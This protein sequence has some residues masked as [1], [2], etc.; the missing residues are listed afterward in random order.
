MEQKRNGIYNS[1][2]L[3]FEESST[4]Q[5]APAFRQ[6]ETILQDEDFNQ[7]QQSQPEEEQKEVITQNKV[8]QYEEE[9]KKIGFFFVVWN[10]ISVLG[11]VVF[12]FVSMKF[13]F[14]SD[15]FHT[16]M[17]MLLAAHV[18]IFVSLFVFSKDK[19]KL[20]VRLKNYKAF[21]SATN[22]ILRISN[23]GLSIG[24][25]VQSIKAGNMNSIFSILST[26][27][28]I[29]LILL[30][31]VFDILCIVFRKRFEYNKRHIRELMKKSKEE[32][33]K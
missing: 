21:A 33:R 6:I 32:F 11:Y 10:I 13:E 14:A 28:M 5:Q 19:G 17:I 2:E 16:I 1:G 24:L 23:L 9:K 22:K 18:F 30:G 25:L 12:L 20:T 3:D 4:S 29:A 7:D 26:L 15:T 8:I 27:G 31:V